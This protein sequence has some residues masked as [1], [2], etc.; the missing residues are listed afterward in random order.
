MFNPK[1]PLLAIAAALCILLAGCG[2]ESQEPALSSSL[3]PSLPMTAVSI[4]SI[5]AFASEAWVELDGNV[6][7][8]TESDMT[9]EAFET[10]GE[11]DALGRCTVAYANV[12]QELMPTKERGSIGQVKPSGWQTAKYDFVDGKY[13]YNRC[14]LIGYQLTAENANE[15]NLIT[16]TRYLNIE[17][18][19]PFENMVAD[20]VKETGNHVLYRVTPIYQGDNLVASGV[21]ME[22]WSVEDDGEGICYNVYCYNAQPGVEIDYATGDNWVSSTDAS[23]TVTPTAGPSDASEAQDYVLNTNS[24]RFHEP[25]CSGAADI[26]EKNR[27]E[28]YGTRESL[29]EDGYTP[30]GNCKP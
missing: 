7:G 26:S 11:L 24:K 18:M 27:Q 4:D 6:P 14:H 30:C 2:Q 5:P 16:G 29:I 17:G 15:S 9:T 28:Y 23:D 10:Y 12:C 13:L 1:R 19:L 8:F 20:Y 3:P 25:N 21:Q 22:G